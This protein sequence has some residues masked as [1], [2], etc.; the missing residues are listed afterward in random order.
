M[1]ASDLRNMS[2]DEKLDFIINKLIEHDNVMN[3]IE[4][5]SNKFEI[6]NANI[7]G[8]ADEISHL[9][10]KVKKLETKSEKDK[11]SMD[12]LLKQDTANANLIANQK[13]IIADLE[14]SVATARAEINDLEQ[15]GRR[16]MVVVN[17]IPV[18]DNKNTSSIITKLASK[19]GAPTKATDIDVS[20]RTIKHGII[21][22]F[23]NRNSRDEFFAARKNIRT[24]NLT[25]KDLGF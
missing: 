11:K 12:F 24:K 18:K 20:H 16:S 6:I 19:L 2:T 5:I 9:D 17:G 1:A 10:E 13:K 25:A 23:V 14:K 4:E 7:S 8:L 21:V 15:Y 3:K 22:K